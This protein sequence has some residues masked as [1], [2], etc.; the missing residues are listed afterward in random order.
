[1]EDYLEFICNF[2]LIYFLKFNYG[3]DVRVEYKCK[4]EF[5]LYI[6]IWNLI[7]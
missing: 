2:K 1:M 4:R 6:V 3:L 7:C 5:L